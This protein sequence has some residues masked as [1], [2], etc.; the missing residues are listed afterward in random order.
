MHLT[1]AEFDSFIFTE[2]SSAVRTLHIVRAQVNIFEF[3]FMCEIAGYTIELESIVLCCLN[4]EGS[5]SGRSQPSVS[6]SHT[7]NHTVV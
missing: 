5:A 3:N 2:P 4:L 7:F 1:R 6:L